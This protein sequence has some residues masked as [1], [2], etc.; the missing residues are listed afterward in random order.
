[1]N[2]TKG[3]NVEVD[4]QEEAAAGQVLVKMPPSLHRAVKK[5]AREADL[6]LSEYVRAVLR[7]EEKPPEIED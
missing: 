7:G 2:D 1:M 5:A 3:K 6:F 4:D